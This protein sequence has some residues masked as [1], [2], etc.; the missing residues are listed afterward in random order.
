MPLPGLDLTA[1]VIPPD[2]SFLD[3]EAEADAV[4]DLTVVRVTQ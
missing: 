1:L 3:Y 4:E 2:L